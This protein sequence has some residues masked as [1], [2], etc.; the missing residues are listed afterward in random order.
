MSGTKKTCSLLR[1]LKWIFLV[2]L[3]AVS[4][5]AVVQSMSVTNRFL[6]L[7]QWFA[8]LETPLF[9]TVAYPIYLGTLLL[10][11]FFTGYFLIQFLINSVY[12]PIVLLLVGT[13]NWFTFYFLFWL[14]RFLLRWIGWIQKPAPCAESIGLPTPEERQALQKR[15]V[16]IRRRRLAGCVLYLLAA[17]VFIGYHVHRTRVWQNDFHAARMGVMRYFLEHHRFP[18]AW[19]Q[20]IESTA[21]WNSSLHRYDVRPSE[22]YPPNPGM[23]NRVELNFDWFVQLNELLVEIDAHRHAELPNCV[24]VYQVRKK[25]W[26]NPYGR[27]SAFTD[28]ERWE[29]PLRNIIY[30][31]LVP[32]VTAPPRSEAPRN[33]PR[34]SWPLPQPETEPA[35]S[36]T[37][38][39]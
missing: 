6:F 18:T 31:E 25:S 22:H 32:Y 28:A 38:I 36:P 17:A 7:W 19:D 2:H 39:L 5:I 3:A 20:M 13:V 16:A 9:F 14:I 15:R 30:F 23:A 27:F 4:M 8:I 1:A 37:V 24:W 34:P 10:E 29:N 12:Y 26:K 33:E 21:A 35:P 11:Y